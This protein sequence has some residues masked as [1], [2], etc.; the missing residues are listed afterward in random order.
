MLP[1]AGE[2]DLIPSLRPAY[3]EVAPFSPVARSDSDVVGCGRSGGGC[4]ELISFFPF[5]FFAFLF[6]FVLFLFLFVLL[7]EFNPEALLF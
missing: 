5:S 1:S 4:G 2:M 7:A 3:D 6:A